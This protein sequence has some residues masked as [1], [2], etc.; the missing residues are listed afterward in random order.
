[1]R[2]WLKLAAVI[3]WW[4]M[5]RLVRLDN[6]DRDYDYRTIEG[7]LIAPLSRKGYAIGW[8]CWLLMLAAIVL[9]LRWL[10]RSA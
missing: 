5:A 1:M 8:A 9:L 4:A 3:P 6:S 2:N 10:L 7:W